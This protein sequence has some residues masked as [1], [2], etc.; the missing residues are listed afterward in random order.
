MRYL[1]FIVV[2]LIAPVLQAQ[3]GVSPGY[4]FI[5]EKNRQVTITIFNQA[6]EDKEADVEFKFGYPDYDSLG[7]LYMRYDDSLSAMK[8][9]LD[10]IVKIFPKK[11]VLPGRSQQSVKFIFTGNF[12]DLP[13]GT[14]WSRI[15]VKTLIKKEQIET[16]DAEEIQVGIDIAY[17]TSTILML[18]K[19]NL[20]TDISLGDVTI[21]QDS[22]F[23]Y[24]LID[25][26]KLGNSPYVGMYEFKVI[27][28]IGETVETVAGSHVIY[29]D[30]SPS[31]RV[32]KEK[33]S[34]GTYTANLM[35]HNERPDLDKQF[36]IPFNNLTK[37]FTFSIVD[38]NGEFTGFLHE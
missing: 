23:Y 28:S 24:F 15:S 36:R 22:S 3:H 4:A 26:K 29:F 10:N 18:Q 30:T 19:G 31:I 13:S 25:S 20:T 37:S 5:N 16:G 17:E 32:P 33:L 9:G 35:V 38:N 27:D 14:K 7:N 34:L 21:K 8:Y 1:I 11:V 2:V 12:D 6:D